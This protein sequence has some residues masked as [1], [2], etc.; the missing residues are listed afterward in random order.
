MEASLL[1][2]P[3]CQFWGTTGAYLGKPLAGGQL[4]TYVAGSYTTPQATYTDSTATEQNANPVVL[5]SNG[6][7]NIWIS[8]YYNIALYDA[9]GVLQYTEANVSSF[10]AG[11]ITTTQWQSVSLTSL[12]YVS[13]TVFTC[14]TDMTS[15]FVQGG[16]VQ[17]TVTAGSITGTIV[18]AVYSSVTTVTVLWDGTSALDSGLSAVATGVISALNNC[19]P[20]RPAVTVSGNYTFTINDINKTFIFTGASP[21]ATLLAANLVPSG[22]KIFIKFMGTGNLTLVTGT[23]TVDGTTNPTIN[24]YSAL[25]LTSNGTSWYGA[26]SPQ[27]ASLGTAAYSNVSAFDAAGTAASLLAQGRFAV[28]H[29]TRNLSDST[30]QVSYT[31]AGFQPSA[32]IIIVGVGTGGDQLI[33]GTNSDSISSQGIAS[34]TAL[35]TPSASF[36][37]SYQYGGTT[38]GGGVYVSSDVS[39][40]LVVNCAVNR[41]QTV[42]TITATATGVTMAWTR[43]STASSGIINGYILYMK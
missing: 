16:R 6:M 42:G 41:G 22:S 2:V 7:A 26:Y 3:K 17:A 21:S 29:F 8:G 25:T 13:G 14:A 11:N 24:Q 35:G 5:D 32:V 36:G 19:L 18:S 37:C 33:S 15:T 4:Y 10:A 1:P 12:L 31:G 27:T 30:A 20:I 38:S 28:E 40:T 39:T 9:N 43:V 34:F 23:G